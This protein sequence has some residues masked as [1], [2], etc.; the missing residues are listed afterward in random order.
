MLL[1]AIATLG[2]GERPVIH[3]DRGCHYRWPGRIRICEEHG[4]T[5]S[6]SAKGCSP[7]NAAMEGFFGR[8]KNEFFHCRDWR[9]VGY[10][11]F[12]ERLA[13]YLTHFNETRIKK[14]LG[15][16]SPVQYRKSLGLA[17]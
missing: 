11:R 3:S 7:G 10:E 14:S 16:Q 13:A 17:A 8:L 4:L 5:R 9:G 1:D 12:R 6:M 2:D 15:W